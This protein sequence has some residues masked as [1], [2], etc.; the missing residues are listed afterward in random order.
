MKKT[1]KKVQQLVQQAEPKNLYLSARQLTNWQSQLVWSC[2]L[3]QDQ[4]ILAR[5]NNQQ[6][7]RPLEAKSYAV[8][9]TVYWLLE[10]NIQQATL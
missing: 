5:F 2:I 9:R 1:T 8:L 7:I 4:K 10:Q 6:V 3:V